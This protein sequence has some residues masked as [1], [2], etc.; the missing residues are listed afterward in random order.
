MM[1]EL[2]MSS[3]ILAMVLL[4]TA[5]QDNGNNGLFNC[6]RGEGDKVT[7]ILDIELFHSIRL[8]GSSNV[9]VTQSNDFQV[10]IQGQQNIID[11]IELDIQ[12]GRW[13]I[14]FEECQRNFHKLNFYV[15]I[16][17]VKLLEVSGSGDIIGE[18]EFTGNHF[19]LKIDGSGNIDVAIADAEQIDTRIS[20]SGK[21]TV[22][23]IA[24]QL[25]AKINGSGDLEAFGLESLIGDVRISGSGDAEVTVQDDLEVKITGSGDVYYRGNPII[26]VKITGTGELI[27]AN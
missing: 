17:E 12:D 1:K 8:R 9:F 11:N 14:E 20:G 13:D 18:N 2:K 5:C 21:I 4:M 26:N 22:D 19:D 7:Q 10:I 25:D 23:G 27:S 6:I 16:P 24:Q 15:T 3:V